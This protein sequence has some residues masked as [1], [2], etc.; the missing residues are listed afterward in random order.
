MHKEAFLEVGVGIGIIGF[1]T[2]GSGVVKLLLKNGTILKERVGKE[3]VLKKVAD[4]D[5]ERDRGIK[6]PSELLTRNAEHVI[7]DPEVD[8]VVELIGGIQPARDY[9][10]KALERHKP[11]VT[12][13]K[14]LLAQYGKELFKFAAERGLSIGFE[15]SVGGGIPI[16]KAIKEALVGNDIKAIFGILNGTSNYILTRMSE[17]GMSFNEALREAQRMGIAEAD[18]SLDVDGWDAAHKITIL[19]SLAF[20]RWVDFRKVYVEGIRD[21][22][23]SDIQ[24]AKEFG[25]AI[26]LLAIAKKDPD[27]I[28]IRVHPTMVPER[29]LLAQTRGYFNAIYVVGDAVGPLL[30]YGQGAG[31]LPTASAV[32]SD[33]ADLAKGNCYLPSFKDEDGSVKEMGE[34]KT[35]YYLRFSAVDRPGVLSKISGILGENDISI[36]SVIQKG[37][38]RKGAVPIV[39]ITHEAVERNIKRA[40]REIDKL[41]VIKK[42]T[43]LIRAEV[44]DL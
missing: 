26:K 42:P 34:L 1:G 3:L 43:K 16:V 8:I 20:G 24:F 41:D 31:S 28:Q 27:G 19:A 12:A 25:Y 15:A 30:F 37:R 33:L 4:I 2:V 17:E 39:M 22:T 29:H 14:A 32:L 10:L 23:P 44:F 6:L 9:I 38:T 35:V 11:V 36:A 13:N 21:L 18:P 7:E 40:L 5:L